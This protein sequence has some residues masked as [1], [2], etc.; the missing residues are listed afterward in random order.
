MELEPSRALSCSP[1]ASSALP[2]PRLPIRLYLAAGRFEN[3][4]PYS[5]LGENRRFRD[6]L[7]ARDYE[8]HY[9]N[10]PAGDFTRSRN[11]RLGN[12]RPDPSVIGVYRTF[13]A[14]LTDA[15]IRTFPYFFSLRRL[16]NLEKWFTISGTNSLVICL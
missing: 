13:A 12:H 3:F 4:N 14:P 8:V 2:S 6:I 7:L 10:S 5:L 11:F 9:A 16:V 15:T 1:F